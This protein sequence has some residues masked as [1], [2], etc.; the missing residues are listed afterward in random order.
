MPLRHD[1]PYLIISLI[2]I[3]FVGYFGI[4]GSVLR[5]VTPLTIAP[6]VALVGLTLFEHAA[7]AAS[8]HWGIAAG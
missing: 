1:W 8:Q 7:D 4:I 6:T 5:V 2:S 3:P